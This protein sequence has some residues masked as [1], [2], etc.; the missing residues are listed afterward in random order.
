MMDEEVKIRY[1]SIN[2]GDYKQVTVSL[3]TPRKNITDK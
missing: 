2:S 3:Y 1:S